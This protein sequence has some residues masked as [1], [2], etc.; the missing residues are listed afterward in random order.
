MNRRTRLARALVG[1]VLAAVVAG[2]LA[3]CGTTETSSAADDVPALA[4]T[5]GKVDDAMAARRY[6]AAQ[7]L[8]RQLIADVRDYEEA[9]DL[10]GAAASDI[11]AAARTLLRELTQ[12]GGPATDQSTTTAEVPDESDEGRDDRTPGP[13]R[14]R[15]SE[16]PP[17]PTA[18][19]TED[20]TPGSSEPTVPL[21]PTTTPG[22]DPATEETPAADQ[23][24]TPAATPTT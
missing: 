15:D 21:D 8:L 18:E 1:A 12:R 5:L 23:P 6:P 4:V 3:G 11:E 17:E 10:D 22:A 9:G 13:S 7:K 20:P 2:L 16:P 24:T 14:S 19:P